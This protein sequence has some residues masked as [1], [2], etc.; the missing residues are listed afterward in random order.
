MR[1]HNPTDR[2]ALAR[3]VADS[4]VLEAD[5]GAQ[6][7]NPYYWHRARGQLAVM[8]DEIDAY[9]DADLSAA[10]HELRNDPRSVTGWQRVRDLVTTAIED[11]EAGTEDLTGAAWEV[12]R[13]SRLGYHV[14]AEYD[15][16]A[17]A[18]A[19][20]RSWPPTQPQPSATE[21]L[22]HVV[23][24]FRDRT[25]QGERARNLMACLVALND[26]TMERSQY[27]VT[28]V[29]SD[30]APRWRG[31]IKR[32]ADE[33]L[34]APKTGAFNKC[35]TVNVGVINA[36]QPAPIVC[37]L[38]A[39]AL[40]DQDFVR[41]NTQRFLRDGTG[42]LLPFRDLFY[43]DEP[44]SA[45]AISDRCVARCPDMDPRRLRGFLVHRAP[46]V[47]I[48]LRRDVF[49]AVNG[50]DERFEGWGREDIDF[51]LRVQ[52]A[53]TFDLYD[54]PMLHLHHPSTAQLDNGHTVNADIPLLSWTPETAIGLAGRFFDQSS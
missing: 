30:D 7:A 18:D 52:L 32:H 31:Q 15:R 24:P 19:A 9:G 23:I 26:Q 49:D 33:Y 13:T 47:C 2:A 46:G 1:L 39:D 17:V 53:T 36:S 8:F 5:S 51:V 50:M 16:S 38:D 28:V 54:D 29:E 11:V 22:V 40:V 3:A 34:F 20:W 35:W 12:V 43:L 4:V 25:D 14:G 45:R 37:I 42:A 41:R 6:A 10:V 48:W 21:P 44:A 27:R